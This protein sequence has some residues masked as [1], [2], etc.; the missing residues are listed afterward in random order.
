MLKLKA[1]GWSEDTYFYLP[2]HASVQMLHVLAGNQWEPVLEKS[3]TLSHCTSCRESDSWGG[4]A[5]LW[6]ELLDKFE[7]ACLTNE[8]DLQIRAAEV[9]MSTYRQL[10]LHSDC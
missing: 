3:W 8:R 5:G 4:S 10:G 7:Q 6:E 2:I 9:D 1:Q